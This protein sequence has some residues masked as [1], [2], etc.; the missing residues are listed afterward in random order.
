MYTE[1]S[2][3]YM[4]SISWEEYLER[5][6]DAVR[7]NY[8]DEIKRLGIPSEDWQNRA[9]VIREDYTFHKPCQIEV[10]EF[11]SVR[12]IFWI[13]EFKE[14]EADKSFKVFEAVKQR[15]KEF[16]KTL[17]QPDKYSHIFENAKNVTEGFVIRSEAGYVPTSR[18]RLVWCFSKNP[19]KT[20]SPEEL[21]FE[22]F[23][24]G[25]PI[26]LRQLYL[27]SSRRALYKSFFS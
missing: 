4:G 18:D 15:P 10:F 22:V 8:D 12:K 23:T 16:A 17:T 13:M 20:M 11:P 1:A 26:I 21:A 25:A 2:E 19:R 9:R 24:E 14:N 6:V 7:K 5:F 27:Q 3:S